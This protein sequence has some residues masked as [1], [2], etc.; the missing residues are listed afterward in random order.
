MSSFKDKVRDFLPETWQAWVLVLG[1]LTIMGL[2]A[3]K[4]CGE[5]ACY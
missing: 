2:L 5:W 4:V 1:T 3:W